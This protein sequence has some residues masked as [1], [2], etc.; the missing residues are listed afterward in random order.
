MKKITKKL[1]SIALFSFSVLHIYAADIYVSSTGSNIDN[2]GL[3]LGTPFATINHAY[4]VAKANSE[5][6]NI[7]ISGEV[8]LTGQIT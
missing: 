5:N 2:D 4:N 7:I 6:D 3:S 1:L 8:S